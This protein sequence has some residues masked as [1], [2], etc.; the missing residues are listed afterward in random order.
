MDDI[1]NFRTNDYSQT[2]QYILKLCEKYPFL[3]KQIIGK[4][5]MG[6]DIYALKLGRSYEYVLLAAAFHGSEHITSTLLLKFMENLCYALANCGSIAGFNAPR[7]MYGRAVIVVPLVNP[8][9]CEVSIHS[10]AGA[11]YMAQKI[12]R[13][14]KNDY[15]H[16]NANI[17]GVDINHNFDAGW[18]ELH[19]L[20]QKNGILGPAPTRYGGV[21]PHSEPETVALVDLCHKYR[22][23][24]VAAFHSQ[25]EV[26]YWNYG[27]KTPKNSEKMAQ[28]M[29]S[30]SGY[31]LD[32]PTSL[33][34]GGGFKDWFIHTFN[35][36]GFTIEVGKGENPLDPKILPELYK[37]VEE[38]IMLCAIM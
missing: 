26:I 37:Q 4:S 25:G 18:S 38:M 20:E 16:W 3:E 7:A 35:R 6:R 1:V 12:A 8:D 13:L 36:P 21:K 30:S 2:K 34:T 27:S 22:I 11:G 5:C 29:A 10:A 17:R 23:R 32:V 15:A 24:H 14:C 19:A 31:A 9:G 28:I 33:A